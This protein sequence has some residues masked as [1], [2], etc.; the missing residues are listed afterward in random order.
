M[1][2]TVMF[3]NAVSK[4]VLTI[5]ILNTVIS[6]AIKSFYKFKESNR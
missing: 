6:T 1:L 5:I 4:P 3:I 2:G